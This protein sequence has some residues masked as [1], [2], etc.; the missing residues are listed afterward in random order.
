M[1]DRRFERR[2]TL[3]LVAILVAAPL[4]AGKKEQRK[5]LSA[6]YVYEEVFRDQQ[7]KLPA[8][9]LERTRC[10]AIVP[11]VVEAAFVFGGSHGKGVVSCRDEEGSWSPPM[12]LKVSEGSF[13]LQVGYDTADIL[14]FFVSEN[15]AKSLLRPRFS[16][17]GEV[18]VA[19]GPAS[20]QAGVTSDVELNADVYIY[21]QARGLF[22]GASVEGTRL[23]ISR[24]ASRRY[25]GKNLWPEEVLFYQSVPELPP[26]CRE[27]VEGLEALP[28]E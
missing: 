10:L 24:K 7:R 20:R 23:A 6:K 25:Y 4:H 18:S 3:A 11:D 26:G 27:F 14:L 12:F 15:G 21:A 22:I 16:L 8:N 9:L 28:W 13:G 5:V 2:A 19:A 17:G 1:T